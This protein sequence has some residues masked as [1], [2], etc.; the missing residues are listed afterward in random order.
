MNTRV[1]RVE[2]I[3]VVG[4]LEMKAATECVAASVPPAVPF[5]GGNREKVE[6]LKKL[7]ALRGP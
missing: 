5:A 2:T 4:R 6:R 3:S 7:T 1:G